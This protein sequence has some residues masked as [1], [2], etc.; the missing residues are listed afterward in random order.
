MSRPVL[1]ATPTQ[2]PG[3]TINSCGR[4]GLDW[5]PLN[6]AANLCCF[7]VVI[8]LQAPGVMRVYQDVPGAVHAVMRSMA[9]P[10]QL[11]S[12]GPDGLTDIE[13]VA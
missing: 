1:A 11:R 12:L 13:R 9:P 4:R 5:R 2:L 6:G 8:E 3:L 7:D 10:H